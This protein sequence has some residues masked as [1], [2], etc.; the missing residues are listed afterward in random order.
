MLLI[1][2]T[3]HVYFE[4]QASSNY[5]QLLTLVHYILQTQSIERT[6]IGRNG[7]REVLNCL[8][9]LSTLT[10]T[11]WRQHNKFYTVWDTN[12]HSGLWLFLSHLGDTANIRKLV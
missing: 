3:I 8:R 9:T 4:S 2:E 1:V 12:W 7:V 5:L 6:E 11:F 10:Y